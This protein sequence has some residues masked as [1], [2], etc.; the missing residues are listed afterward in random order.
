M[1]DLE[2]NG[3]LFKNIK[4]IIFDKDGTLFQLYPYWSLVAMIRAENIC[5]GL[6]VS[7]DGLAEW[8]ALQMGV[9]V[10]RQKMNPKGPIGIYSRQ[11]IQNLLYNKLKARGYPIEKNI[12]QSAFNEADE[13]ISQEE[14]IKESHVPV[15]GMLD[16]LNS[17]EGRSKGA[18]F[19]YDITYKLELIAR[20]FGISG[21]FH[22][23]LGGDRILYPKP[24]P[25]GS[26]E[27]MSKLHISPENT[28][29]IGDSICDMESG[30]AAGCGYLIAML[31]EISNCEQLMPMANEIVSDF[32]EIEVH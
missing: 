17:I 1:I 2:I 9:D 11:Y 32:M 20:S 26:R 5:K 6:V 22:M 12:I 30:R 25:W 4:L 18:I 7:E 14:R 16:F 27:I 28:A 21:G 10:G 31:S 3:A 8:I 29:L 19:S 13:Y 23:F 15:R 24:D